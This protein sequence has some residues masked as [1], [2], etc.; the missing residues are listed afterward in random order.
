MNKTLV[1]FILPISVLVV[2]LAL[3]ICVV[4]NWNYWFEILTEHGCYPS[5]SI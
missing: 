2:S 5:L 4:S 1:W 3:M